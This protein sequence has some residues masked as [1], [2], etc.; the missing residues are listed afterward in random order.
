MWDWN[1]IRMQ[2]IA[3]WELAHRGERERTLRQRV[4]TDATKSSPFLRVLPVLPV[5]FL[6]GSTHVKPGR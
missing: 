6:M 2:E 4:E 5:L 3:T 1:T